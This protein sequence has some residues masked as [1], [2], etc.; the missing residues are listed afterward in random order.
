MVTASKKPL[1]GGRVNNGDDLRVLHGMMLAKL[2]G[3]DL[4]GVVAKASHMYAVTAEAALAKG[5]PGAGGFII[6]YFDLDGDPT[7]MFRIRYLEDTRKGFEKLTGKKALRYM[8]P[9]NSPL[10][11]YLS[12]LVNW[13]DAA[14]ASYPLLITEGELKAACACKNGMPTIGLGGVWSFQSGRAN[15]TLL[16]V[17]DEFQFHGRTVY[18]MY[19]SDAVTNPNVVAAELRLAKRL[20]ERGAVVKICRLPPVD[21][22]Y[23]VGLDDY[24]VLKGMES[25]QEDVLGNAFEYDASRVLHEL[26]ERVLYVKDPGFIWDHNLGMRIT[27]GAFKEHAY[28][29]IF[30]DEQRATKTGV[31]TVRLPAAPAWLTWPHRAEVAGLTFAPG[32]GNI[33]EGGH[34]NTWKGWGIRGAVQG[35]VSPWVALLDHL[36]GAEREARLYF[37]RWCAAPLQKPGLK[38]AV[39][40]AIWGTTHGSGKTLV[41]H[42]LM[43]MYGRHAA[44]LK[45]T[46]LDDDRNEWADSKQFVLADDITARGDRKFMRRLMTMITQKFIRLNPKFVPSYSIPDTINYYFTSN[47][48]DALYMDDGDRRFFI[49]E[50]MAGKFAPYREYVKWRDSEEGISALWYYLLHLPLGDFDA[51][52][53]A[54]DTAG[55]RSMV[56]MGKSDLGSWVRELKDNAPQMFKKAGMKGDLFSAKELHA[57]FDPTGDKRTTTNALARELKRAGFNAPS[58]GSSLHMPDGSTVLAYAILNPVY[59]RTA[60]WKECCE[61]YIASRPKH[62]WDEVKAK[63]F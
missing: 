44:E 7:G 33:T 25:L 57:L 36:F 34:L 24:I 49:W 11:V 8:Q 58:T 32:E 23:K 4:D 12:P 42:T 27:P 1:K 31:T 59:W 14:A 52:A 48:P 37:E 50:V 9:A 21:D 18:I 13:R 10:E 16:P 17:F 39:A 38:M 63:K 51:Q 54:L 15:T 53:P 29:N 35:D 28:S 20:S 30:Y 40:A 45:D 5:V 61:H 6:P 56:Y 43:R 22:I 47:D 26:N 55:K 60:K 3:S 2:I 46:D 41:G 19:D 62:L